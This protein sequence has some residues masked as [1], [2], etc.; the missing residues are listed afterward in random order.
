M[1]FAC[2]SN[3]KAS[4]ERSAGRNNYA[5]TDLPGA[6]RLGCAECRDDKGVRP[7]ISLT[8]KPGPLSF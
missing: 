8:V 1:R 2:G 4:I 7:D 5:T 3:G 6:E